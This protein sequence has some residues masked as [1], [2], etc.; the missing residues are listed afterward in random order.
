[1]RCILTIAYFQ[2]KAVTVMRSMDT[3]S[4]GSFLFLNDTTLMIPI[5]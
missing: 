4:D 2:Y 3:I 5:C 1:M